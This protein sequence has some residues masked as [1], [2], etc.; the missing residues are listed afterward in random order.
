MVVQY[1]FKSE[2]KVKISVAPLQGCSTDLKIPEHFTC[3]ADQS[4]ASF[5]IF[6]Y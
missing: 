1:L 4:K 3:F 5:P 2:T 6:L